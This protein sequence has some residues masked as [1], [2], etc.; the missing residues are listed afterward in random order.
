MVSAIPSPVYIS[1]K[2]LGVLLD[3][4][5]G[6]LSSGSIVQYTVKKGETLSGI[7]NKFN[8]SVETILLANELDSSKV[9]PGQELTILP[10]NGLI[11]MVEKNETVKSLA[12]Q[13][14]AKSE[15]IIKFNNLSDNGDIYEGDILIIPG[16]KVAA[17]TN[18]QI[19]DVASS[20]SGSSNQ[21]SLPNSYFIVPT[22]GKISQGAHFSYVSGG[23]SYYNSIDIANDIG[24]PVRAAAGGQVQIVKKSWPY[25]NYITI[26]HPN[27]VLTLYAHLSG[28]AKDIVPGIA[29]SQGQIIGYMGN[30]GKVVTV[31]GTGSHL[32][33]ETRGTANP[34][35][36][37]RTGT[38]VSY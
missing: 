33:F 5:T 38:Q 11:H 3:D 32:H 22:S 27:G 20:G 23:H 37:Y 12:S 26:S 7:A 21:L 10:T 2:T 30:T 13:Y 15:D 28:F 17:K 6:T 31:S 36:Q 24:T 25:G 16:G 1:S 34:L 9:V 18:N 14:K 29:V 35:A 19:K 4:D 8:I